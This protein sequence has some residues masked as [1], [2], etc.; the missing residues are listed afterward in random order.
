MH[1]AIISGKGESKSGANEVN[2]LTTD[3][4]VVGCGP[5]GLTM[6]LGL[7]RAGI[8]VLAVAKHSGTANSP[9]AHITNQRSMEAFRQLGVERA[10]AAAAV[11]NELM[12]NNVWST[13]FADP[14]IGRMQA[15][16]SG[17]KR[18]TD[19]DAASPSEMCNIAQHIMEPVLLD[20]VVAEGARTRFR[21]EF[22]SL[23][24]VGDGVETRL[25]DRDTG[26]EFLVQSRFVIGADGANSAVASS[27]GIDFEGEMGLGASVNAWLEV[28]LTQYTA[29]RPGVL[30]WMTRPGNDY[31]VGS[32]TWICV[33]PWKDWVMLFMY[34]P[35]GPEPDLSD[36]GI[37]ARAR[38][39]IGDDSIPVRV[40]AVSKWQ[41][42]HVVAS[43]YR[44]GRT[45]IAGDAAHRH[46][47][48]NGLGTNT[49]VQDSF[50]L[51]WKLAMVIKGQASA[52]LLDSYSAERQPVGRQVVD[53]AMKSVGG[54]RPIADALGFRPEQSE[55]EGWASLEEL[56]GDTQ[57]GRERRE[58]L[59]KAIELQN[60]QFNCHG[61]E[62]GQVYASD[63]ILPDGKSAPVPTRDAELFYHPS[64]FPGGRLPHVW[65]EQDKRR[66]SS[67]DL[68]AWDGFTL[69]TGT[70]GTA[71]VDAAS[72][73]ARDCGIPLY[74]HRIGPA[75]EV[76]DIYGDW[77]A[78]SEVSD[79]GCVLVRPDHHI[80]WRCADMPSDPA[81]AL[82]TV[83][84]AITG[85]AV[86]AERQLVAPR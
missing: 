58:Q 33:E 25:R 62:M 35:N 17:E 44:I 21:S 83:I 77:S 49:S 8:D 74:A 46:P 3:V 86:A 16:G 40:K 51:A 11:P 20:A 19:Y 67:L 43:H 53:R 26:E 48:A 75:C 24:E 64:T 15:W 78:I 4:L 55:A 59:S 57:R 31:W 38:A 2:I 61:V 28:D 54:M 27:I 84:R 30:Y 70:G 37:I 56:R 23:R 41:I 36:E 45:F 9:R 7:A 39:T 72:R 71:W 13:S 10:V 50:N 80:A 60:Y 18:R 14:E 42:N 52:S 65:L 66:I 81:A 63:A 85:R 29:H 69:L 12:G 1:G 76:T 6:A 32:G 79:S 5:A 34:D 47:P 22:V 82:E 73:V 68:C